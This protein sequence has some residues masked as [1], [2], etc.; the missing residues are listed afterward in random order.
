[1]LTKLPT[2]WEAELEFDTVKVNLLVQYRVRLRP[3]ML[4]VLK[5]C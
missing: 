3:Y 1:M 2:G 5:R 4:A